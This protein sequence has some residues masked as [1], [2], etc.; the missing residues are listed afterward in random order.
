MTDWRNE[1]KEV[2]F[3]WR[4]QNRSPSKSL[5]DAPL[6]TLN[7][8]QPSPFSRSKRRPNDQTV[9]ITNRADGT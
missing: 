1:Q 4:A 6:G 8:A 3:A 2:E 7:R 5:R 9:R